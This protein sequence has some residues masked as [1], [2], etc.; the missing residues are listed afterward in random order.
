MPDEPRQQPQASAPGTQYWLELSTRAE[1]E[2]VE[3]I[4]EIFRQWGQGV[5]I[6]EPIVADPDETYYVDYTQPVR[7]TTYL[8]LNEQAEEQRQR[9]EEALH[10]LGRLRP[11]EPLTV[12][13]IAEADWENAWKRYFFVRHVG[14]RLVIVPSWRKYQPKAGEV[15]LDLD[16]GMAFGTGVHPTTRLCLHLLEQHLRPGARVLDLG[17]GSGILAIAAAKLGATSVRAIDVDATAARVAAEN[18]G[19]NTVGALVSVAQG[20]LADVDAAE[21]FD[22]ILAN[23]NL[24][25]IRAVLPDLAARLAPGGVAILS[26]VLREHEPTLR[27]AIAD[28][29]LAIR[30]RRRE[31][32]WLAIAVLSAEY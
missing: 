19:R 11:I 28:A 6:E 30:Q 25:V 15:V 27:A 26:G 1:A 31:G 18:V 22:L 4:A 29:G 24:R 16:P 20:E 32:D 2:T 3:A 12:R 8:P 23:I 14:K 10:W 13:Q 9:L 7:I 5:A 21:R 17:T